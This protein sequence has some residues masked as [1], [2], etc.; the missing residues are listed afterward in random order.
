MDSGAYHFVTAVWG[1]YVR[2][3]LR[4]VLPTHLSA[5]NVPAFRG[6]GSRYRIFTLPEHLEA[7]RNA[8]LVRTLGASMAVDIVCPDDVDPAGKARHDTLNAL[9]RKAIVDAYDADAKL[10]FLDPFA[11]FSDGSLRLLRHVA[12]S[13]K[14]AAL[15]TGLRA[16]WECFVPNYIAEYGTGRPVALSGRDVVRWSLRHLHP[17]IHNVMWDAEPEFSEWPSVLGWRVGRDGLLVHGYHLHPFLIVPEQKTLPA[18]TIDEAYLVQACPNPQ[19]F[20]F[21]QDSD[22]FA[23]V[24]LSGFAKADEIKTYPI[25]PEDREGFVARWAARWA[26]GH[27]RRYAPVPLRFHSGELGPEWTAREREAAEI[28]DR[29]AR[30]IPRHKAADSNK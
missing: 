23:Y 14:R 9:H 27:H 24:K 21:L 13:G 7:I 15:G 2:D 22:D 1:P 10:V 11:I 18:S 4:V 3:F 5:G 25:A 30:L 19:D 16:V 26:T 20:F 12:A 8:E 6:T 17:I 29:V 28:I